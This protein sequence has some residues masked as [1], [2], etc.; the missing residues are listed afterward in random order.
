[1]CKAQVNDL[2]FQTGDNR[3]IE[4]FSLILLVNITSN[5]VSNADFHMNLARQAIFTP[6]LCCG[7]KIVP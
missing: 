4:T 5:L 6:P 1:M 2:L 7:G 3:F